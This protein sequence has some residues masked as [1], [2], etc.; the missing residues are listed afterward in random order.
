MYDYPGYPPPV[1]NKRRHLSAPLAILGLAAAAIVGVTAYV[2]LMRLSTEVL[3]VIATVGCASG[4]TLPG[5]LLA[6]VVLTKRAESSA[7]QTASQPPMTQP[8]MLIIPPMAL[9]QQQTWPGPAPDVVQ[10]PAPREF[11]VVGERE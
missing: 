4:V 6:L 11:I 3:T 8:Q 9:P 1:P 5:L 7:R 2:L 10:R